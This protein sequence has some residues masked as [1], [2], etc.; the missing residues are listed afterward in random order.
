MWGI[1]ALT[2]PETVLGANVEN[3]HP[4][5]EIPDMCKVR[6]QEISPP[7]PNHMQHRCP[8]RFAELAWPLELDAT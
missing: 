3:I 4:S 2:G 1:D 5:F 6:H 8:N 7:V